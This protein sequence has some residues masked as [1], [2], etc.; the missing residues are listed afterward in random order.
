M[1]CAGARSLQHGVEEFVNE[2]VLVVEDDERLAAVV[3]DGLTHYGYAVTLSATGADALAAAHARPP[4]LVVLDVT[5][6]DLDGVEVC[7]R[8]Q[9][10]NGPPVIMLTARDAI[11]D[12][13]RGLESG[14]DDYITKPFALEELIARVRVVLRRHAPR[15]PTLVHI[16]NLT[17]DA[18]GRRVWRGER[19]V[20]LTTR[21]FDLL[22]CLAQHAGQA[23]PTST[24]L[25][26]VWGYTWEVESNVVKVYIAYL[27]QKLNAG[28]ETN[29]IH[30]IR[31][32]GY[33]LRADH[34]P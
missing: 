7:R 16:S 20:E 19:M 21:E 8:L 22:E 27:R 4:A 13:V 31:G 32:V 5:L 2:Q 3:R 6:P 9:A 11:A 34:A 23:L 17:L 14:A 12:K 15:S 10:A 18:A 1:T 26:R 29:L 25:E 24:L 30:A 28:G 33:V